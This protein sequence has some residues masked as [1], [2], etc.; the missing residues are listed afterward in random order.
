MM[1]FH[2]FQIF[3]LFQKHFSDSVE[4]FTNFTFSQKIFNFHPPKFLMTFLLLLFPPTFLNSPSFRKIY[5]FFYMLYVLFVSSP[6]ST[7]LHLCITQ[8]TYWTPLLK[9]ALHEFWCIFMH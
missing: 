7:M 9:E 2:L 6:T 8:C 5:V 4:N 3:P 1:H